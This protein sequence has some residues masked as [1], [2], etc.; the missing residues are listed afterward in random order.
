ML[1]YCIVLYADDV[2]LLSLPITQLEQL[3]H[4]LESELAWLD[5]SVSFNK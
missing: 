5:M 4:V 3:L 1:L 2:L